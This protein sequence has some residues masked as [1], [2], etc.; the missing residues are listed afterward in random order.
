MS[1]DFHTGARKGSLLLKAA[2]AS[3][4]LLKASGKSE[5][6]PKMGRQK[7]TTVD[8]RRPGGMP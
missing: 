8:V 7:D 1:T 5:N 3:K 6:K 2:K 4:W